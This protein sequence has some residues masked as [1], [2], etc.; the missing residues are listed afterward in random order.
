[1]TDDK[2][3]FEASIQGDT[4]AFEELVRKYQSLVCAIT[5]SA[6]ARIDISEELA[7]E[8][9]LSAWQNRL[10]LKESGKFRPWLCSI[11]R[12]L[13]RKSSGIVSARCPASRACSGQLQQLRK[14][15]AAFIQKAGCLQ[16]AAISPYVWT[17]VTWR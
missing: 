10:Q 2:R 11:A 14:R 5:F 4:A 17:T 9:F 3:L 6:T 7:Q 12:N 13:V 16:L 1:M 15:A 8:A